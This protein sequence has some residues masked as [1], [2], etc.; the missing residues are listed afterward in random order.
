MLKKLNFLNFYYF[1]F[2]FFFSLTVNWHLKQWISLWNSQPNSELTISIFS[3]CFFSF[4]RYN[5]FCFGVRYLREICCWYIIQKP[6]AVILNSIWK[7]PQI[8]L[9]YKIIQ[10]VWHIL[11][12]GILH[13]SIFHFHHLFTSMTSI[14]LG[15]TFN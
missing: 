2:V 14:S 7:N 5:Y 13:N 12:I 10:Q 9:K 6:K 3:F 15:N 1:F 11:R 8:I 4:K